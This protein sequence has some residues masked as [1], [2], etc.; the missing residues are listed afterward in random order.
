M[1]T[2]KNKKTKIYIDLGSSTV[3]VYLYTNKKLELI[4][5]KSFHFKEGFDPDSGISEKNKND[6]IKY[7][8]NIQSKFND[9]PIKVFATAI[10]RKLSL[11]AQRKLSDEFFQETGLYLNIITHD[12]ENHY[13][14][15]ALSSEYKLNSLLLLMNI[16]GGSVELIVKEKGKT[17]Y[18]YNLD[19][20]VG[21]IL[22]KFPHLNDSISPYS[23]NDVI[24]FVE[25]KL[26]KINY[27]TKNAI[28]SGGELTF[29]RLAGYKLHKNNIFTDKDHPEYLNAEDFFSKNIEIFNDI[30]IGELE[31]LM[32][33]NPLWMHGARACSAIAQGIVKRFGV[34]NIIPSDSNLIHGVVRKEHRSVVLSGSFRKHL[35]YIIDIK[36]IL[37][38][39]NIEVLSPRFEK[40]ESSDEKFVVFQGEEGL[41]PLE[42]ERYYLDT[43]DKC[44]ALIVCTKDG[45]VGAST[46]LEIG[47]AQ[48]IGKRII[49]TE[50][51]EEFILQTL[52]SEVG[53]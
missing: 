8:K 3:K 1:E 5:S 47:Y 7:I 27:V 31:S 42:L 38:E 41:S 44:D 10:F 17:K 36:R 52:P 34:K 51:P 23:L 24:S 30:T 6:L 21:T 4:E 39:Q 22:E 20:G 28:Y 25:K 15:S 13:L 35:D 43:I 29:M 16:G 48:A 33:S 45:Y 50:M 2:L 11:I 26:P 14:E 18:S 19:F 49:F 40:L 9:I 32:P 53:L 37:E 46:L 12:L